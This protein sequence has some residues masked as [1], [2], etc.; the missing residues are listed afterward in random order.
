[1]EL[2]IM[3]IAIIDITVAKGPPGSQIPA[4]PN[5]H[6][7]SNLIEEIVELRIGHIDLKIPNVQRSG[8]ELVH[9]IA[10]GHPICSSDN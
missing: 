8:H 7:L 1:M 6:D 10:G 9:S 2:T 3:G 4:D 5:R